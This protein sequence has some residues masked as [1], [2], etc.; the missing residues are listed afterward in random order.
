MGAGTIILDQNEAKQIFLG[1]GI[2]LHNPDAG[3]GPYTFSLLSSVI[4]ALRQMPGP[5][6]CN[7]P[8]P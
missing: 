1:G 3:V 5:W 4:H 6:Q 8:P 7:P 2:I